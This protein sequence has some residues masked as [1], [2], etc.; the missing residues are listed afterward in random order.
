[1]SELACG[2]DGNKGSYT[3]GGSITVNQNASGSFSY[4]DICDLLSKSALYDELTEGLNE[5]AQQS[6]YKASYEIEE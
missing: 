2:V 4:E 1:M 5:V 6:C 3:G